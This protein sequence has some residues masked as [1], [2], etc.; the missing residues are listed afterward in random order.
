MADEQKPDAN[1]PTYVQKRWS[2]HIEEIDKEIA[3]YAILCKVRLLD[4]GVI[5]K[6]LHNDTSVCPGDL[7]LFDKMRNLLMLHYVVREKA[8]DRLGPEETQRLV[9]EVV[10]KLRERMGGT[11]A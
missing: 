4:P 5:E 9:D 3:K 7:K 6:V 1:K 11:L 8:V 10:A 2:T